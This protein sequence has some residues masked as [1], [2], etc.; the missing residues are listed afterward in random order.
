MIHKKALVLLSGGQDSVTCLGY[1]RKMFTSVAAVSFYYNQRHAVEIESAK[2]LCVKH[3]IPHHIVDLGPLLSQ[4]VTSALTTEG[5][6]NDPAALKVTDSHPTKPGLPASFVPGRNALFLTLA[7]AHAQEIGAQA[8][9]AG[10]CQTDYSGYPD[11]RDSFIRAICH[12]L[13]NG[14]ETEIQIL[15][16][17]MHLTKGET[18]ALADEL[19]ILD[20]VL[21]QSHT[22]YEGDH[23]TKHAWGYGCGECPACKL[24]AKGYEE[25]LKI[26]AANDAA[27]GDVPSDDAPLPKVGPYGN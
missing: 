8:I 3:G 2:E 12:A 11:C 14:Y 1:A 5:D 21:W 24:R 27:K 19:G 25:Y 15:T 20:E 13:N 16:P 6:P 17:L 23:T 10:M 18:F 7:H 26:K 22:C 4:L 9:V